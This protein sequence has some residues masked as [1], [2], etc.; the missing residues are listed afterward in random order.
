MLGA[1]EYSELSLNQRDN[2]CQGRIVLSTTFSVITYK[3]ARRFYAMTIIFC[4]SY[5]SG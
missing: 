5:R 1:D 3:Q 4:C 2:S